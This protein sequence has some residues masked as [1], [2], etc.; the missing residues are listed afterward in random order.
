[1]ALNDDGDCPM[2]HSVRTE[3]C[4]DEDGRHKLT[5]S[6]APGVLPTL[7]NLARF[8]EPATAAQA[9]GTESPSST[10][11]A[12]APPSPLAVVAS[13]RQ[14]GGGGLRSVRFSGLLLDAAGPMVA[15]AAATALK[16]QTQQQRN[17][18]L[19]SSSSFFSPAIPSQGG[20]GEAIPFTE[21]AAP[22]E[23]VAAAVGIPAAP[24][25]AS[26]CSSCNSTCG[27]CSCRSSADG[28]PSSAPVTWAGSG[29]STFSPFATAQVAPEPGSSGSALGPAPE[30]LGGSVGRCSSLATTRLTREASAPA[31]VALDPLPSRCSL[32]VTASLDG[33][34]AAQE[35]FY[36]LNHA[37]QT[38]D[39]VRRQATTF[40]A[41]DRARMD[42][43]TALEVLDELR[44]YEAALLGPEDADPGMGLLEHALQSAEA[45]RL[46]FPGEDW[47]A[48]AGLLHGEQPRRSAARGGVG[49]ALGGR[50]GAAGLWA[51]A[52]VLPHPAPLPP[53]GL[54]KL[55]AHS[56]LGAEPQWAVCGESFPVGCRFH[57]AVVHSQL[58][59]ANPDRRRRGLATPTGIYSPGCGLSSVVMS[60]GAGEY[61][62]LVLC[63]NGSR[64]P[65]EA[66][67]C[68]RHQRF[69][70]LLRPGSPYAELLSAWDRAQLPRLARFQELVAYHRRELGPGALHGEALRAHYS[71]LLDRYIPQR[72]L[73]W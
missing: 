5:D 60:W 6:S 53:P 61:L 42:A 54:G 64:L 28:G 44:E 22:M 43:W 17:V 2:E 67:F 20:E 52:T 26:L 57:P 46:A 69:R 56:A 34:S 3:Y 55:L 31:A 49:G 50:R 13:A 70:A 21:S 16:E 36:R 63:L 47:M 68:L 51:A 65:P 32:D 9:S 10:E 66:L 58:F 38:L 23:A 19:A 29:S 24:S 62:Y 45:C 14:R 59:A 7:A 8:R 11:P 41:L 27:M 1:M 37:R 35:L 39:Y 40:S 72:V 4:I 25:S 30:L 18:A 12:D 15:L 48:L 33:D 71:A 73:R